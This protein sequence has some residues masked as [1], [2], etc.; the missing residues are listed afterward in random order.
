[1]FG[2]RFAFLFAWA[3]MSVIQ[4]G[5]IAV[6]AY[7]VGDYLSQLYA[8]GRY[9]PAIYAGSMV[10]ALTM[11]N[12]LGVRSVTITQKILIAVQFAGL[13]AIILAGLLIRPSETVL[14]E[15]ATE[16]DARTVSLGLAMVFV[17]LTFGGRNEAGYISAE[18]RH[19]SKTMVR[20]L[21]V[22]IGAMT[23]VY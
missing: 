22:S 2:R 9:S 23:G 16:T 17:L 18:L 4:T 11:I 5:S 3:R 14:A 7:I 10:I 13:F 20:V 19:G 1:A 6:L 21:V 8:L 15:I 12:I